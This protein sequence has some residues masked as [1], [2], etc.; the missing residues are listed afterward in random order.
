MQLHFADESL[1]YKKDSML[2]KTEESFSELLYFSDKELFSECN[3][4]KHLNLD[5][6]L[7]S[8]DAN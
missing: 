4:S 6:N 3:R 1:V 5:D 7:S 8:P 2:D